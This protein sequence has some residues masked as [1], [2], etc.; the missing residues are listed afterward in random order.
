MQAEDEDGYIEGDSES[1]QYE[2]RGGRIRNA[3]ALGP[4]YWRALSGPERVAVIRWLQRGEASALLNALARNASS[5][6]LRGAVLEAL[7]GGPESGWKL[8]IASPKT[9]GAPRRADK[10]KLSALRAALADDDGDVGALALQLAG[11]VIGQRSRRGGVIDPMQA[12]MVGL[13][14]EVL[15]ERRGW[16]QRAL[17]QTARFYGYSEENIERLITKFRGAS[18]AS[19][20]KTPKRKKQR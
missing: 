18:G 13:H 2:G 12:A 17:H 4:L 19:A 3:E 9:G 7:A 5:P 10:E 16:S 1:P 11:I 20:S 8:K 14:Y 6:G 15:Y